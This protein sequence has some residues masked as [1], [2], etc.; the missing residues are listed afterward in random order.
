MPQIQLHMQSRLSFPTSSPAPHLIAILPQ[1]SSL[2][3]SD[4][5]HKYMETTKIYN[6]PLVSPCLYS[7]KPQAA[8]LFILYLLPLWVDFA[9]YLLVNVNKRGKTG[10]LYI[11]GCGIFST[12]LGGW[13]LRHL[14]SFF[15]LYSA[16]KLDFFSGLQT[17]T[18]ANSA[19]SLNRFLLSFCATFFLTRLTELPAFVWQGIDYQTARVTPGSFTG[20]DEEQM[21][22]TVS[23]R[24][25]SAVRCNIT[26]SV[27]ITCG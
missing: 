17:L 11:F 16:A 26:S 14:T 18:A 3:L 22:C 6:H 9:F 5:S 21:G 12:D 27:S 8:R 4:Y 1:L 13:A 24:P 7:T 19:S 25:G 15:I 23:A 20:G 2:N 10:G